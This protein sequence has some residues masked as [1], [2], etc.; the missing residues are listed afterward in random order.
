MPSVVL[1]VQMIFGGSA[2][3]MKRATFSRAPLEGFG[4]ALGEL[5]DAAVDVRVVVRVVVN[6]RVDDGLRLLRTRGRVEVGQALAARGRL[7]EDRKVP[8]ERGGAKVEVGE[9]RG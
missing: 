5:V 8:R 7:R 4:G 2:A 6:E 9:H 3:L 1:R